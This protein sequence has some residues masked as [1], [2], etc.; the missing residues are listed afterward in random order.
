[1]VNQTDLF[2]E[3]TLHDCDGFDWIV[4]NYQA[5]DYCGSGIA[6]GLKQ[7]V[8]Y[9]SCLGHCSCY[10]PGDN[11]WESLCTVEKFLEESDQVFSYITEH[12]LCVWV[13]DKLSEG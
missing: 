3:C 13:T 8:L 4:T 12:D 5:G 2:D 6:I 7:G 11:G 1:M 9:E 10:G